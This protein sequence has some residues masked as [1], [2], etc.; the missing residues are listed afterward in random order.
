MNIVEELR[1][2]F[3]IIY[4]YKNMVRKNRRDFVGDFLFMYVYLY[5]YIK[6][7]M[8]TL[9]IYIYREYISK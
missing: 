6:K 2:K 8:K 7:F 5:S 9:R 4:Y 3:R 1:F